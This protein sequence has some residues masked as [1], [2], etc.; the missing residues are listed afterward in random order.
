[1]S[2]SGCFSDGPWTDWHGPDWGSQTVEADSAEQLRTLS[3]VLLERTDQREASRRWAVA[4]EARLEEV[5]RHCV[6]QIRLTNSEWHEVSS[7]CPC[8]W[9]V[10]LRKVSAPLEVAE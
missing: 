1:M 4:L 5:R 6:E 2:D 3:A 9:C 7:T 10:L 8:G